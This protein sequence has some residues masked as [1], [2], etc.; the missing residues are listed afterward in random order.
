MALRVP[1]KSASGPEQQQKKDFFHPAKRGA[2]GLTAPG[3]LI[4]PCSR[5]KRSAILHSGTS[6]DYGLEFQTLRCRVKVPDEGEG[7]LNK[8]LVEYST[9]LAPIHASLGQG[10]LQTQAIASF[11]SILAA[12]SHKPCRHTCGIAVTGRK[13]HGFIL[14]VDALAENFSMFVWKAL[15]AIVQVPERH[16]PFS[17][18]RERFAAET[19]RR[20]RVPYRLPTRPVARPN[21][22]PTA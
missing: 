22:R 21:P 3:S 7:A 1:P 16:L 10:R 8:V 4:K 5:H 9:H 13:R 2:G 20:S 14:W 18:F 12:R 6:K 15:P 19:N 11:G 17:P